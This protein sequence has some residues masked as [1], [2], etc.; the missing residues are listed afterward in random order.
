MTNRSLA[1]TSRYDRAKFGRIEVAGSECG[2]VINTSRLELV[3]GDYRT[4]DR[5]ERE[6]QPGWGVPPVF[7]TLERQYCCAAATLL[8]LE[9]E[10]V[11][12][13][14]MWKCGLFGGSGG[15]RWSGT[16]RRA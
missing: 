3:R 15:L 5:I 14:E 10:G 11:L 12:I 6:P 16:T 8:Y 9:R 2:S 4:A 13:E 7:R 1:S